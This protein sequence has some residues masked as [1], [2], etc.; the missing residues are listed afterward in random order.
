[1]LQR[2]EQKMKQ[3]EVSF[4]EE[5]DRKKRKAEQDMETEINEKRR[6]LDDEIFQMEEEKALHESRLAIT[7]DQLQQNMALVSEEQQLLDELREKSRKMKSELEAA[8]AE[9]TK[10]DDLAKRE[11]AEKKEALKRKLELAKAGPPTPSPSTVASP[12][13]VSSAMP[14]SAGEVETPGESTDAQL[15]GGGPH[16]GRVVPISDQR[17]TS[18]THPQAWHCLYRMTRKP[19]SCDAE[20]YKLWHEGRNWYQFEKSQVSNFYGYL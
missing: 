19:D 13:N 4:L 9:K 3:L 10:Q 11:A 17:F 5:L 18:S 6:K 20:I 12:G 2:L 7:S 15:G 16:D 1:M 8:A 14:T